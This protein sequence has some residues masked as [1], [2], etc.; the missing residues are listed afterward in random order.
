[1]LLQTSIILRLL[2]AILGLAALTGN[3]SLAESSLDGLKLNEIQVIGTHNSYHL[4]PSKPVMALIKTVNAEAAESIAYSHKPMTEQLERLGIRQLEWDL[5]ADPKGGLFA[6]PAAPKLIA[7]QGGDPGPTH[8]PEGVLKKP[9]L[10]II[11]APDVDY[12]TTSFTFQHALTELHDWSEAHPDHVP[13]MVLVE[14]KESS[15]F[16]G[17]ATPLK[18]DAEQFNGIDDE[19]LAVFDNNDIL[20]PDDVRGDAETLRETILSKGWPLLDSV[21][22]KVLFA[23]DNGGAVRDRYLAGHP[24]LRDRLLF[25]SVDEDDPAAAWFRINESVKDFDRIQRLVKAGFLIRTRADAGTEQARKNDRSQRDK[26]FASGAQ[27]IST[28]YPEP[29]PRFSD[30]SVRFKDGTVARRNPLKRP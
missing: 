19:I 9:G 3:Q 18:F 23:L 4:E 14:V 13:V 17:G 5:Y 22:G 1:V 6:D 30:Y 2:S 12:L 20:S 27:F 11:H 29:D 21:R 25:A 15:V 26:A 10:K 24:S 16:P 7:A 28:D 8:D